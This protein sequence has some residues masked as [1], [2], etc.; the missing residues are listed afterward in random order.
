MKTIFST[1]TSPRMS[2]STCN[3]IVASFND[4]IASGAVKG[5][6]TVFFSSDILKF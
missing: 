1:Y 6:K 2:L 3:Y 4:I 5:I